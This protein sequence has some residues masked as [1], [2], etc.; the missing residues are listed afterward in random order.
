MV[1]F[2]LSYIFYCQ[3]FIIVRNKMIKIELKQQWYYFFWGRKTDLVSSLSVDLYWTIQCQ[4][5]QRLH[6][7]AYE[8]LFPNPAH[9]TIE[10]LT[11]VQIMLHV[12]VNSESA[13]PPAHFQPYILPDYILPLTICCL[14]TAGVTYFRYKSI[15]GV[16][17]RG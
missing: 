4:N 11:L 6:V 15:Q 14:H 10:M 2:V 5:W 16:E 12:T 17:H 3:S 13:L 7:Q 1:C 9:S 8:P